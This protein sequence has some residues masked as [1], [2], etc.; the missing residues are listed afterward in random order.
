[1][2]KQAQTKAT[3]NINSKRHTNQSQNI[4]ATPR[5][6]KSLDL[7]TPMHI[8]AGR[9]GTCVQTSFMFLG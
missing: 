9:G 7:A 6:A 2:G 8:I 4:G 5:V 3:S 1:M